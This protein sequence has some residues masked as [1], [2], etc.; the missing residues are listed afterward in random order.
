M[1]ATMREYEGMREEEILILLLLNVV[2]VMIQEDE[3]KREEERDHLAN[4][5]VVAT[6]IGWLAILLLALAFL[7]DGWLIYGIFALILY[8]VTNP[9]EKGKRA[10]RERRAHEQVE[11]IERERVLYGESKPQSRRHN[12]VVMISLV[13]IMLAFYIG[14]YLLLAYMF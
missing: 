2:K 14:L 10:L 12:I 11:E 4:Q 3:K 13:A 8:F 7:D 9:G 1:R 6:G 5:H